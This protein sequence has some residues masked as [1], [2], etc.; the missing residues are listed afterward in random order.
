[1]EAESD[2][3]QHG[4][5][6]FLWVCHLE[7]LARERCWRGSRWKCP[8]LRVHKPADLSSTLQTEA[9]GATVAQLLVVLQHGHRDSPLH[10]DVRID[11]RVRPEIEAF[12]GRETEFA[13]TCIHP[14]GK[15]AHERLRLLD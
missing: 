1:M 7:W 10:C 13:D 6:R 9:H 5:P 11:P 4:R 3:V 8:P 12:V 15:V 14:C 2:P